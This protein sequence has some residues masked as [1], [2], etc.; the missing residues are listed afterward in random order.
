MEHLQ[1]LYKLGKQLKGHEKCGA[2]RDKI[3]SQ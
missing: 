1:D 2:N 3:N